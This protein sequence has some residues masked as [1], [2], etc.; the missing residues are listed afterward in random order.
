MK[1]LLTGFDPF[2]GENIN[3]SWEAL[4]AVKERQGELPGLEIEILQVPTSFS[5]VGDLAIELLEDFQPQFVL[6]IGQAGGSSEIRLERVA[7]NIREARIADN[8]GVKPAGE[9]V[10]PGAPPAYFSPLPLRELEGVLLAEGIPVQVSNT[11]GTF[12]CNDLYFKMLHYLEQRGSLC[13]GVFLHIPFLPQQ[14][15]KHRGTPSMS[16]ET[17]VAALVRSLNYLKEDY[18]REEE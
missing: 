13:K 14:A 5:R 16:L 15:V 4:Q 11:A 17:V 1:V 18:N 8:Q 12:V 9:P 2:G 7:I 10:I 6:M 3:P